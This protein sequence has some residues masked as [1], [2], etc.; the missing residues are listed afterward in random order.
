[1]PL[2]AQ[3][4]VRYHDQVALTQEKLE[5]SNLLIETHA[6]L[7]NGQ[8]VRLPEIKVPRK[9]DGFSV[10]QVSLIRNPPLRSIFPQRS[11]V[12]GH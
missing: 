9:V 11:I 2:E 8:T 3:I 7:Q 4:A 1:M 6:K 5:S 10:F 12:T